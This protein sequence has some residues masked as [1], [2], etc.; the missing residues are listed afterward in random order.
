MSMK[1]KSLAL[2]YLYDEY[3]LYILR[4]F[5]CPF[6]KCKKLKPKTQTEQTFCESGGVQG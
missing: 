2:I 1:A 6:A 4:D 5:H 3:H